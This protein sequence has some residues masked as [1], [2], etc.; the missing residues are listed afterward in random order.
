MRYL[1]ISFDFRV[2]IVGS[3][4]TNALNVAEIQIGPVYLLTTEAPREVKLRLSP[5]FGPVTE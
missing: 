1:G 5:P 2:R 3:D 4:T